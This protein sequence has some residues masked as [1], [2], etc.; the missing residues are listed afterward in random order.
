MLNVNVEQI[1]LPLA[2]ITLAAK[3]YGQADKPIILALHGWLDNA[4]S[5]IPLAE[6]F[7]QQGL[8][9][10]YQ[11]LCI[12]WPGHGLSEHRPGRYPL[13]WV[14]YIYDLQ[15]VIELVSDNQPIILMGHSLG[16]II[17][18]AYNA[19]LGENIAKLVLIEA[20]A[21]LSE[22][23]DNAKPRLR[24]GLLQQQRFNRQLARPIPTYSSLDVAI[25]ARH[26]LTGLA[27]PWCKL[28]TERNMQLVGDKYAWRSDPRLKLDS[29]NRFTFEQ[30]DALMTTSDTDTLFIAA[31]DGYKQLTLS[32][33][34]AN[35]WFTNIKMLTLMGDH[36][37]HMGNANQVAETIGAFILN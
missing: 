10:R 24:K 9:E 16:G 19:C 14:D 7:S 1:Q 23:A 20:L 6:A 18:S 26:Q 13:H 5:F 4:D 3:R 2:H 21:P 22:S 8:F 32:E 37:L 35:A 15:A 28:I 31:Q 34:H 36:H 25:H 17:A 27:L 30:V 29:L 33:Q 12:D 11:L